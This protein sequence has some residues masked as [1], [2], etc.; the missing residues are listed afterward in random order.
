L[1]ALL[2]RA[3]STAADVRVEAGHVAIDLAARTVTVGGQDLR[4]TATEFA[5]LRV[6]AV[7]AGKVVT[8]KQLLREVWGPNAEAQSQYLR[9]Y[10][11]HLR[12]KLEIPGGGHRLLRTE[13]GVGYRLVIPPPTEPAADA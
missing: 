4:L 8:H 12:K 6:L 3:P 13:S 2:R 9:V 11:M 7:N 10:M 5:L 1:R